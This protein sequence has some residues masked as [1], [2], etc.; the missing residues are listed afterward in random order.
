MKHRAMG[1]VE[2]PLTRDTLQLAPGLAAGMAIR[3][4]VA[5]SEPP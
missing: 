3:A 1:F 4:E 5:A 2:I